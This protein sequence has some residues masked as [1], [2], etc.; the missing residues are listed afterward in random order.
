[1]KKEAPKKPQVGDNINVDIFQPKEGKFPI[2]RYNGIIC[3]LQLPAGIKFVPYGCTCDCEITEVKEKC[4]IVNVV[5]VI[6]SPEANRFE[7]D[8]KV[9]ELKAAFEAEKLANKKQRIKK[10]YPFLTKNEIKLN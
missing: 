6:K 7:A 8:Q 4:F 2:G 5:E 9:N 1:M 10:V 3:K